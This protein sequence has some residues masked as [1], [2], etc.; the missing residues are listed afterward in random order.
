MPYGECGSA[1]LPGGLPGGEPVVEVCGNLR[2]VERALE[3]SNNDVFAG[4]SFPGDFSEV[5]NAR[6]GGV[7]GL[8]PLH[9]IE[10]SAWQFA[11]PWQWWD[12][13]LGPNATT[14]A[15]ARHYDGLRRTPGLP[16]PWSELPRHYERCR[17]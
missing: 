14:A 10:L 5:A 4:L 16:V 6:N 12:E 11:Y 13:T 15:A 2:A 3:L 8:F 1:C 7:D 9:A 17:T